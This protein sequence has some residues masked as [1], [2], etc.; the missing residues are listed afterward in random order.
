MA[1]KKRILILG[2]SH[3]VVFGFRGELIKRLVEDGHEV[4]TS[5]PNGPFGKGEFSAEKYGCSF[6]ESHM[7]RR[8]TN[9]LEDIKI[10]LE[11]NSIIK[12]IC[13]DVVLAYTVK[14]NIYGGMVC[15]LKRIAFLPNIT[16]LG[17]ALDEGGVIGK[18][19]TLLY[20][21]AIN[22]AKCVFF[23]NEED[24]S[25]FDMKIPY[26]RGVVL[27]GSGVNLDKYTP[28]VYP[29]KTD[30]IR[31]IYIARIMKNKGIEQYLHAAREVKRKYPDVEF[32]IC[33]YCE[34]DYID[35]LNE[36]S[37]TGEII[38]HGLVED[39][40]EYE[41]NAHCVVLPSFHPEG[42]SNVLLEAG[43]SARP[44]ITTDRV[45][46]KETVDDGV[47]GF[48]VRQKDGNDLAR[49]MIQFIE[50][51]Y[52]EKKQMGVLGRKK[53]EKHYDRNIIIEAYVKELS[54]V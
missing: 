12:N 18:I 15:R 26:E 3:L 54:F 46:C 33:G 13:P 11:Y 27:P 5:F 9:P 30:P 39:V 43:A 51:P 37:K 49:K 44:I 19:T 24:K 38:N 42:I 34:E 16:G 21:I 31:F 50:M 52:E 29:P 17:K 41:R 6:V 14:P 1:M 23:Q 22:K 47:T 2:N 28:L 25:F 7:D 45:G 36:R 20:K 35:I 32:H 10:V 48:I 4:W 40:R 53:I 8:G